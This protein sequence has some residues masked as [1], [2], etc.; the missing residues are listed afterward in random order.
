LRFD[1]VA[2]KEPGRT[3]GVRGFRQYNLPVKSWV[4]IPAE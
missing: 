1:R 3:E 4:E 2:V